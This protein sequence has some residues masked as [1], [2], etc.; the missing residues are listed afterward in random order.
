MWI[1]LST[2]T[3]CLAT[4]EYKV[5]ERGRFLKINFGTDLK[6]KC[7]ENYANY[8]VIWQYRVPFSNLILYSMISETP[9]RLFKF[10]IKHHREFASNFSLRT[11]PV[12]EIVPSRYLQELNCIKDLFSES[13][14]FDKY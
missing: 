9:R 5:T 2:L 4:R 8:Y 1:N 7:T 13:K 14:D 3:G 12:L 6:Y 10:Y 11:A